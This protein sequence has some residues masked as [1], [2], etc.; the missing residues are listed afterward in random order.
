MA[1]ITTATDIARSPD[2]VFAYVTDPSRFVEWQQGVVSGRMEGE[3]PHMVGDKCLT[4]RRIGRTKRDVTSVVTHVD[5]PKTWGVRA[6]DGPIRAAVDVTVTPLDGGSRSR[7]TIEI[8]FAGHGIGKLLVPLVVRR[9]ARK[10]MPEDM[11]SLKHR[12]ESPQG[13]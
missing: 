2:E 1:P 10:E 11:A 8:D 6:V 3:G 13:G 7:L 12:L 4:T 5:P 9:S